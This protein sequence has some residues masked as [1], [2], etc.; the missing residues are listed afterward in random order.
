MNNY[1]GVYNE[2]DSLLPYIANSTEFYLSPNGILTIAKILFSKI[3][4]TNPFVLLGSNDE[5]ET[6]ETKVTNDYIND[7]SIN[8]DKIISINSQ[9]LIFNNAWSILYSDNSLLLHEDKINDNLFLLNSI[10]AN[11]LINQSITNTQL[12][13]LCISNSNIQSNCITTDKILP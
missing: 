1:I 7:N 9:K 2:D 3:Q 6:I 13:P 12:A 11:K 10:N 8:G 5:S 4:F